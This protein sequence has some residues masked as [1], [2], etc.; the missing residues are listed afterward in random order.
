M[1][2]LEDP[3]FKTQYQKYKNRVKLWESRFTEKHG[4]KPNKVC[5]NIIYYIQDLNL[6]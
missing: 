3:T 4:R 1:E 5:I 2:I 6:I